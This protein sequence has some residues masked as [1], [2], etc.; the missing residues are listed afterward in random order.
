[1]SENVPVLVLDAEKGAAYERL[2]AAGHSEH[3]V[4]R[5][6]IGGQAGIQGIRRGPHEDL[7]DDHEM[8][9]SLSGNDRGEGGGEGG[10]RQLHGAGEARGAPRLGCERRWDHRLHRILRKGTTGG[11][12]GAQNAARAGPVTMTVMH[13]PPDAL[14]DK[15]RGAPISSRTPTPP[16]VR[17]LAL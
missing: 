14:H 17:A 2:P 3:D 16:R 7:L 1:R 15:A 4:L 11:L 5:A 13:I 6:L 9:R 12:A 8:E 10:E